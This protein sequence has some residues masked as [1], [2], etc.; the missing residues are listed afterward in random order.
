MM[1][2]Q[3]KRPAVESGGPVT[4]SQL[5]G[6]SAAT[7]RGSPSDSSVAEDVSLS[8]MVVSSSPIT[9]SSMSVSDAAV[10]PLCAA[11]QVFA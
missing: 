10:S 6:Y 1:S 2:I 3:E 4:S 9:N 7:E 5:M 11:F 8:T